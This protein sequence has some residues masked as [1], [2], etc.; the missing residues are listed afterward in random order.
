MTTMLELLQARLRLDA[1]A[2]YAALTRAAAAAPAAAAEWLRWSDLAEPALH[3]PDGPF[4][5]IAPLVPDA[6]LRSLRDI[7]WAIG[8]A[9]QISAPPW[10]AHMLLSLLNGLKDDPAR[11]AAIGPRL[12]LLAGAA[13]APAALPLLQKGGT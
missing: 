11:L 7:S 8:S 12:L 13:A 6:A 5:G 10:C 2:Q 3:E 9:Q 4:D 1:L